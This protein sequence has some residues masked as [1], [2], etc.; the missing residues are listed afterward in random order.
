MAEPTTQRP[1]PT[2]EDIT[3]LRARITTITEVGVLTRTGRLPV[4]ALHGAVLALDTHD[5]R[6]WVSVEKGSTLA[7]LGDHF[8]GIYAEWK[9]SQ[10][11]DSAR[12]HKAD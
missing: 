10:E 12:N 8:A 1:R 11:A 5:D 9:H 3:A 7:E 4:D 6:W 2:V